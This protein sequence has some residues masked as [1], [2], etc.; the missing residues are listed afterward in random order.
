[1]KKLFFF[2]SSPN[3]GSS[4]A[5][6]PSSR[7]EN[8]PESGL[9]IDHV[10]DK[11]GSNFRSPKSLFSNSKKQ[12]HDSQSPS[13]NPGLRKSRSYSSGA[14]LL[15]DDGQSHFSVPVNR[16]K[17][18]SSYS[19]R[20]S[21]RALTPVRQVRPEQHEIHRL[22]RPTS[23]STSSSN[24]STKVLDRYIDGEQQLER[25]KPKK[26][27]SQRYVT[28][29]SGNP[30]GKLPPRVQYTAPTSPT[31]PV[32][33]K[34]KSHSFRESKRTH[35]R[36]SCNDDW[37]ENDLGH[38]SPR[39]LAKN[40][41]ER[42][43]QAHGFPKSNAKEVDCGVPITIEDVYGGSLSSRFDSNP[44]AQAGKSSFFEGSCDGTVD[45]YHGD[46]EYLGYR[47]DVHQGDDFRD[48]KSVKADPD[49]VDMELER[50]S[51]EAEERVVVLSE[52]LEQ[53]GF[54]QDRG[55]DSS[56][57]VHFVRNLMEDRVSMA[58]EISGLL[59]S[60]IVERDSGKEALRLAK[61]DLESRSLRLEKEKNE[62]QSA[63]E[64]E[65]DR[66]SNDWSSKLEKC[67][68]EEHRLRERVRE[69]AEQNV[70]LQRE[71]SA[72]SQRETE[73]KNV[74]TYSEQQV[75]Q[76]TSSVQE[77]TQENEHLQQT[78]SELQEKYTAARQDLNCIRRNF[79]ARDKECKEL[80]K[81]TT[82][83]LRTCSEQ[84][85]TIVGLRDEFGAEI[86][87]QQSV[88]KFDKHV[89]KIRMEQVRL[90]G[91]ELSLRREVESHRNEVDSLRHE[92][93]NLLN[94]LKG[95][96]NEIYA[97]T[98]KLDQEMQTRVCCLQNQGLSLLKE[99]TQLCSKLLEQI[100]GNA[101]ECLETAHRMEFIRN[102]LDGH[103]LVESD[104]KVQGFKRGI[105][106]L[107]RGLQSVSSILQEKSNPVA[108]LY[109]QPNHPTSE[110]TLKF[111]LKAEALLTS[112]L[113][114]KLCAK[115][116]EVEQ[117]QAEIA[118]AVRGNDILRYEV[119]NAMDNLSCVTHQLKDF[120]LQM[121]KKDENMSQLQHDLQESM[122]ELSLAKGILPKVT[123]ERDIMWEEVK[124]YN[125]KNMLLNSEVGL[126]KKKLEAL[127]EDVLVKE[128]QITILKDSLR[129]KRSFDLLADPDSAAE[130][131]LE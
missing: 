100:K 120:E 20:S 86:E 106:S 126:L 81:S 22:E 112:L 109:Q 61:A 12:V 85:K 10:G 50:R 3:D 76:L 15:D 130:F 35:S 21:R 55:F 103:F 23:G 73:S 30:G 58:I 27:S 7:K 119:Q 16:S 107:T 41:I 77:L 14:F 65:L 70:S 9:I 4:N 63:L 54:L 122:K 131:L 44:D 124:Q 93:M 89:T 80:Q 5:G 97:A 36:F 82:R 95:S 111:E 24:A 1:M 127:D 96:G 72:F 34:P 71:V 38:G 67:Q 25:S 105:E 118:A 31:H 102:G 75:R 6:S 121:S 26:V 74:M 117:L 125:E 113:R 83:L 28:S 33:D 79:E 49:P 59:K 57:F 46:D 108:P 56:S 64:K 69:L 17:S 18:P 114:E 29:G 51:K 42:L 123:Q 101:G 98:L 110:D 88:D 78:L 62:L 8:R 48:I 129:K 37:M 92:N 2:R 115:E 87:N 40:V 128:G 32:R 91:V 84:E 45:M 13:S 68:L 60:Q 116:M 19:S 43:A 39:R 94:R 66:R 52:E 47:Q 11:P 104:V 99:S 53:E 90:T